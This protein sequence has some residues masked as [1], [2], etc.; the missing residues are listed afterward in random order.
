[1][2]NL[3]IVYAKTVFYKDLAVDKAVTLYD[4]KSPSG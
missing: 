1:L 3:T 4:E 2:K